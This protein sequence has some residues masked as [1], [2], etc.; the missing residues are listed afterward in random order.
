MNVKKHIDGLLAILCDLFGM[1]QRDPFKGY[2]WPTQRLGIKWSLRITYLLQLGANFFNS[3]MLK[4]RTQSWSNSK[5]L[6]CFQG[7]RSTSSTATTARKNW[8][9]GAQQPIPGW[10][11]NNPFEK[12]ESNWTSSPNRGEHKKI[13]ETNTKIINRVNQLLSTPVSYVFSAMSPCHKPTATT[14]SF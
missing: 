7:R 6:R 2:L 4:K 12:Y 3:M 1:A 11:F 13:F 14:G 10:W 8:P 9:R 5:L